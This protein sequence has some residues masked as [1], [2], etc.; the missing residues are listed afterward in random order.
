MPPGRD[1]FRRNRVAPFSTPPFYHSPQSNPI[2][3][4]SFNSLGRFQ[5]TASR[6]Y[7]RRELL[8]FDARVPPDQEVHIVMDNYGTHKTP[9]I[10]AWF[11]KRPRF[12]VH[13]TPTYG[14]WLNQVER[15]FAELTTKQIRRGASKTVCVGQKAPMKSWPALP[16]SPSARSVSELES[17]IYEF[18]TRTMPIGR[19]PGRTTYVT[20]HRYRTLASLERCRSRSSCL[21]GG[22]LLLARD[23]TGP[24]LGLLVV[25]S[26][27]WA[28]PHPQ[29]VD[30]LPFPFHNDN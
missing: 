20:N 19:Y 10:R 27:H 16:V 12:D 5:P 11:A 22:G 4:N 15:W 29:T 18:W 23:R 1:S 17:A 7:T 6:R 9:L 8:L 24:L 25:L 14:S 26:T 30:A 21:C 13:F 2:R 28:Q 3:Q